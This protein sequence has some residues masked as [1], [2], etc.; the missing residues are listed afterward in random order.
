MH[1]VGHY[2]ARISRHAFTTTATDEELTPEFRAKRDELNGRQQA[3]LQLHLSLLNYALERGY[4]YT[5]RW[6][7]IFK[8]SKFIGCGLFTST[9]RISI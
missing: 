4:S 8:H 1:L 3:L 7:T 9:K 6:L 2:K 5:T